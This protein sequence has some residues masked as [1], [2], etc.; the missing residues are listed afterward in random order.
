MSN[1]N[2]WVGIVAVIITA[3]GLTGS[4][5][6][7]SFYSKAE[8]KV[9]ETKLVYIEEAVRST[10]RKVE[11]LISVTDG[12]REALKKLENKKDSK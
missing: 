5:L 4:A 10:D 8:G 9:V 12:A 7:W 11:A 3:V 6:T 2:Q 1:R